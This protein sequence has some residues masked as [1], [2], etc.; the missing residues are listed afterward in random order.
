[1]SPFDSFSP[2]A[3]SFLGDLKAN[4]SKDWFAANKST[5]EAH[6]KEPGKRF[7]DAMA[8]SLRDLT[9]HDHFSK[10]FRIHRDVRFSKDKTPYNAHLHLAFTPDGTA[11]QPPMWF[12]GLSPDKLTLGCGVLQYEKEALIDFR[13]A[14]AGRKGKDLIQLTAEM[15]AA[16]IRIPDPDLRRV[17]SGFDKHHLHSE[18]LRRKGFAA[19]ID[20]GDPTFAVKPNLVERTTE[21]FCKLMPVFG[22]LV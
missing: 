17:P 6:L 19:W 5:Y 13:S 16:G 1:M 3:L 20:V 15:R 9:C 2:E 22:L 7:A 12:F 11:G 4:N 10:V 18:A 8:L 21:L 14:M